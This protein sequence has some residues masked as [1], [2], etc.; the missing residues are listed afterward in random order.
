MSWNQHNYDN[1]HYSTV[2][3]D[4]LFAMVLVETFV[5]EILGSAAI[6]VVPTYLDDFGLVIR[7][8][9]F[10]TLMQINEYGRLY[11]C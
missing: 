5:T 2:Y 7:G 6:T 9:Y 8:Q 1:L 10:T 3:N 11:Y 4:N